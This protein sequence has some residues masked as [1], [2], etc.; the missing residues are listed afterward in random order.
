MNDLG[1]LYYEDPND[2]AFPW[3]AVYNA[4]MALAMLPDATVESVIEGAMKYASP[5]IEKEIRHGLAIVDKYNNPMDRKMWKEITDIHANPESPYYAFD[6][7]E[8]YQLSSIYENVTWAFAL[9]KATR[10]NVEQSVVIAV[11]RGR[12]TDC[13]A[14]SAGALAGALTGTSTIPEDWFEILESGIAANPYTNSHMTNR[15]IADDMYR[16]LQN[17]LHSMAGEV[18]KMKA[19]SGKTNK[20][21]QHMK[22]YVELMRSHGVID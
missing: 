10:G 6:R 21:D 12:D 5:E 16:A 7:I 2:D 3:G 8:K 15:A 4:A 22:S 14:A 17:K 9:L 18:E 1:W 20:N 11:N 13:T 19:D